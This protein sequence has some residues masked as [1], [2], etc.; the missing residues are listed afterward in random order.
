MIYKDSRYADGSVFKAHDART[1]LYQVTVSRNFPSN[2]TDFYS[3]TWKQ[4]DRIE[5]VAYLLY[6]NS[7]YWYQILDYNPEIMDAMN[8]APGTVLRV[9]R[10]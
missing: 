9:P 1:D 6:A 5:Q 3:Y 10:V 7:N 4:G 8:I 2:S